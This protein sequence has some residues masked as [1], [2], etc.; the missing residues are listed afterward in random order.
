MIF[1]LYSKEKWDELKARSMMNRV[2]RLFFHKAMLIVIGFLIL[3][4]EGF[5]WFKKIDV[6]LSQRIKVDTFPF[7]LVL[8]L[9]WIWVVTENRINEVYHYGEPTE[10]R[11]RRI[12][13][14]GY[15]GF[16]GLLV[17][18]LMEF[19]AFNLAKTSEVD[20]VSNLITV[21]VISLVMA[22]ATSFSAVKAY[23]KK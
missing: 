3:L 23:F 7:V 4:N 8:F 15:T 22:W 9:L 13:I 21:A 1:R 2:F 17:F 11:L 16:I 10:K 20:I 19:G 18:G 12:H 14:I 5:I 6:S